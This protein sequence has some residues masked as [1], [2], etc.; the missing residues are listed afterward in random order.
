M[1]DKFIETLGA[2]QS[3]FG[4]ALDGER[5]E[6]LARY[7]ETLLEHNARLHL[8]A[9]CPAEEFA[10]RHVLESLAMLEFLPVGAR[11]A[12]VGPG[13]GL[14]SIPC[15]LARADLSAVLVEAK[16]KKQ[17]FL[18]ETLEKLGLAAQAAVVGRQFEEIARPAVDFVACRALDKFTQKLPRLLKWAGDAGWLFFGGPALGAELRR[19]P[20]EFSE[21]LLPF[22]EQRFLFSGRAKTIRH[23]K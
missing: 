11:F 7:Y 9:P 13:G 1:S 5:L 16:L 4:L 17:A 20:V 14:P 18:E 21:K 6:K 15:L 23:L 2:R 8:V 3:H 12:D 22:S 19:Q 10:V